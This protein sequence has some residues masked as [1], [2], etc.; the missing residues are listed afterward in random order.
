MKTKKTCFGGGVL[1][2]LLVFLAHAAPG[3]TSEKPKKMT[4]TVTGTVFE[5]EKD[6]KGNVSAVGI[7]TDQ[8]GDLVVAKK[9]V[10]GYALLKMVDQK[11]E[12]TGTVEEKKGKRIITVTNY[13]VTK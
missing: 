11:V 10:K 8:E 6:S 9:G 5:M 7:K 4:M 3:I 12:V 13:T 1:V 2:F